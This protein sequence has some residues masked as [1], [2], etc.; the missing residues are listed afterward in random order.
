VLAWAEAAPIRRAE[1][2]SQKD[3]VVVLGAGAP[4]GCG[5][6]STTDLTKCAEE[7]FEQA[8]VEHLTAFGAEQNRFETVPART[9]IKA[10]STRGSR[11]SCQTWAQRWPRLQEST[12]LRLVRKARASRR[13]IA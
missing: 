10:L 8:Y 2:V 1:T 13:K 5:L 12:L 4:L 7:A 11:I 9:R 3:L 6:P